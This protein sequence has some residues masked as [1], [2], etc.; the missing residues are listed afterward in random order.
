MKKLNRIENSGNSRS[1]PNYS[2]KYEN[3]LGQQNLFNQSP[4]NYN[5]VATG[6]ASVR[7][8]DTNQGD[9]ENVDILKKVRHL[10]AKYQNSITA[11]NSSN[12]HSNHSAA[13]L[14]RENSSN[15]SRALQNCIVL[16]NKNSFNKN[17]K[18]NIEQ[19]SSVESKKISKIRRIYGNSKSP[20]EMSNKFLPP[21]GS[22]LFLNRNSPMNRSPASHLEN[23]GF[24]MQD[25]RLTNS[26]SSH[27]LNMP[28]SQRSRHHNSVKYSISMNLSSRVKA[29]SNKNSKSK[30]KNN[31][32]HKIAEPKNTRYVHQ[33]S[34]N[35]HYEVVNRP[36]ISSKMSSMSNVKCQ[37]AQYSGSQ[38]RKRSSGISKAADTSTTQ[39]QQK[40]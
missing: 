32:Y 36:T 3:L 13:L 6:Y 40:S 25:G 5:S 10:K 38:K 8:K 12:L 22:D 35:A 9:K 18:Y 14:S 17:A 31:S 39:V 37:Q 19:H 29:K 16:G 20:S 23:S 34:P 30:K 11:Q 26:T 21:Q 24:Q 1:P 28:G 4:V 33:R 15:G 7:Y 2:R 27:G